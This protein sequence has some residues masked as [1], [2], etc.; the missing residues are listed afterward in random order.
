MRPELTLAL[1]ANDLLIFPPRDISPEALI[2][3]LR[4]AGWRGRLLADARRKCVRALPIDYPALARI[5]GRQYVLQLDFNP[6]PPLPHQATVKQQPR[7]YQADALT[8]WEAA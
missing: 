3:E 5:L 4:R 1:A 2:E 8:A 7:Q 6:R